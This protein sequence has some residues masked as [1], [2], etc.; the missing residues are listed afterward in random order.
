MFL[1]VAEGVV[2][3]GAGVVCAT[4][5][6]A[7]PVISNVSVDASKVLRFMRNLRWDNC[8]KIYSPSTG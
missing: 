7:D 6:E 8:K 3:F 1:S 4:T 2:D 5:S